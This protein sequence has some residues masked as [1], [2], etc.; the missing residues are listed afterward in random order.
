MTHTTDFIAELFRAANEA[1]KITAFEKRRL[2]ER[3]MR[4]IYDLRDKAGM[5]PGK[6]LAD[7][8]DRIRITSATLDRRSTGDVRS[9]LLLSADMIRSLKIALD[10]KDQVLRDG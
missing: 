1:E 5:V 8:A 6:G 2:L 7:A 9:A 4:T 10:A 3:A